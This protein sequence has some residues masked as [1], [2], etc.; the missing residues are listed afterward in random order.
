MPLTEQTEFGCLKILIFK[1]RAPLVVVIVVAVAVDQQEE[2]S[3]ASSKSAQTLQ[4]YGANECFDADKRPC[5]QLPRDPDVV[6]VAVGAEPG[7]RV[8]KVEVPG[9]ESR[10]GLRLDESGAGNPR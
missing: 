4:T 3:S 5:S 9:H 6:F 1:P 8:F 2:D 7:V 10:R